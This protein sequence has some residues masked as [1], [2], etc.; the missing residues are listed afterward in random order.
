MPSQNLVVSRHRL[1]GGA[2]VLAHG[3]LDL[4][5]APAL[6]A[7]VRRALEDGPRAVLD[8]RGVTFADS[9]GIDLVRDLVADAGRRPGGELTVYASTPVD[10]VASL[11]TR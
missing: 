11:C 4:M 5:T 6:A 3:E 1:A 10:R 8:L 9:T 2:C 7:G